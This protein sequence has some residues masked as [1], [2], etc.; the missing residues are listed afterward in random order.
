M[1]PA[2]F[3]EARLPAVLE[4]FYAR[5]R[6]DARLGPVFDAA[7]GDWPAHLLRIGCFWRSV[8]RG[9]GSYKGNPLA[10]HA[11]HAARMDAA[12]FD[13]WLA[14]WRQTT[15]E[16]LPGPEAAGLQEKAARIRQSLQMALGFA[17]LA[18]RGRG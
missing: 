17:P 16:M 10:L 9:D 1:I 18:I 5:V 4:C 15:A 12:M 13:R 11:R 14:L 2:P 8:M 7:I 6:A 3:D